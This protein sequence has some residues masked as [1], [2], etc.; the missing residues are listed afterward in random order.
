L[1]EVR[2]TLEAALTKALLGLKTCEEEIARH[3]TLKDQLAVDVARIEAAVKALDAPLHNPKAPGPKRKRKRRTKAE[4]AAA[5]AG[6]TPPAATGTPPGDGGAP[7][8]E[9]GTPG[10][11]E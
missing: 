2:A 1:N 7:P 4:L 6:G 10:A 3:M 8:A 11:P 5:A 9:A